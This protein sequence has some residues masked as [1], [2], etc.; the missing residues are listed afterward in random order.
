[1]IYLIKYIYLLMRSCDCDLEE[2][3]RVNK[4]IR[5]IATMM[6]WEYP[7]NNIHYMVRDFMV[8]YKK[9]IKNFP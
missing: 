9:R 8:R 4:C 3:D 2:K 6:D 1:M 7:Y 5:D